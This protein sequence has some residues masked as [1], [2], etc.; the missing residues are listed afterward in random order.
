[1]VLG[2]GIEVV[3]VDDENGVSWKERD[4]LACNLRV[5]KASG[6][7]TLCP[8]LVDNHKNCCSKIMSYFRDVKLKVKLIGFSLV[9]ADVRLL[10]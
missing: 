6:V 2:V 5:V 7:L 4:L 9:S 10:C 1:M 8:R 3:I